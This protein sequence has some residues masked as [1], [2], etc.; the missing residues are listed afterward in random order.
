MK[1][2]R[3]RRFTDSLAYQS[4]GAWIHVTI[5][6]S[7]ETYK[8][9]ETRACKRDLQKSKQPEITKETN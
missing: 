3:Q 9:K 5:N 1:I 8:S 7:R 4:E 6:M 2:D